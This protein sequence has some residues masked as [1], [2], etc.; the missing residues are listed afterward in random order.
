MFT[1]TTRLKQKQANDFQ[2]SSVSRVVDWC[3]A[4]SVQHV[5][6]VEVVVVEYRP[7]SNQI[8][9]KNRLKYFST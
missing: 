6:R 3:Q 4:A 9:Q 5:P 2:A 8:I 7:E 1:G